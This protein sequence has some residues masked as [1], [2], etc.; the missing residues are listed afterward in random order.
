MPSDVCS[1]CYLSVVND[2]FKLTSSIQAAS[3]LLSAGHAL[4]M[5]NHVQP[6]RHCCCCRQGMLVVVCYMPIINCHPESVCRLNQVETLIKIVP[7]KQTFNSVRVGRPVA[8]GTTPDSSLC[9]AT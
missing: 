9:L 5:T 7:V 2:Y 4:D 6:N 1:F 3:T 8:I